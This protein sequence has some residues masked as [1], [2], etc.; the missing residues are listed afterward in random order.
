MLKIEINNIYKPKMIFKKRIF[1]CQI[2]EN[3]LCTNFNKKE[4]DKKT[5]LGF[6]ELGRVFI[7][8]DRIKN[9]KFNTFLKNKIIFLNKK[10]L[11]CDDKTSSLYNK[12]IDTSKIRFDTNLSFEYLFRAD[13]IYDIIVEILHNTKPIIKGK[14]SA[15][16]LHCSSK[17]N[18]N[19]AGCV[20]MNKNN[21]IF[22]LNHLKRKNYINIK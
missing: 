17:N 6:W 21:L 16:F 5:P 2:G 7:R 9:F 4:G 10:M 1:S 19:T 15:I 13:N 20:S 18:R 14:G 22:L 8:K 11:W 12:F 3:K